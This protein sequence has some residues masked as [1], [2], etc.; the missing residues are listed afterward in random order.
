MCSNR[1]AL[2]RL[3][4]YYK[5]DTFYLHFS[6]VT[7]DVRLPTVYTNRCSVYDQSVAGTLFTLS[8]KPTDP[9][10]RSAPHQPIKRSSPHQPIR[11]IRQSAGQP[12]LPNVAICEFALPVSLL[13][14]RFTL[15]PFFYTCN[16]SV[17]P[18]C[19]I[20]TLRILNLTGL[21]NAN[22]IVQ[23]SIFERIDE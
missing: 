1:T 19:Y 8:S 14:E 21:T 11:Q 18:E 5:L 3:G 12:S 4:K 7:S 20:R 23:S 17:R 15:T 22:K 6:D 2:G 13:T 16:T 10:K 9:I